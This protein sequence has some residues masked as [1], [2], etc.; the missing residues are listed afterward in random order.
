M[1]NGEHIEADIIVACTGYNLSKSYFNF[2][3]V[4]RN[5]ANISEE[6]KKDGPSA[7]R[8]LLVKQSP[9]LWTIGVP[10]QLLDMHL[11]SWQLRMVLIISSRLPNQS[12]KEK[13]NQLELPT[14][15]TTTG[16]Q[17]FKRIE[18]SVF[19]TP[20]GGCVSWY[21]DAKVNSTVYPWSQFHYWW[22]TFPKL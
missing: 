11:L 10:I 17:L 22:I 16:L 15:L 7:Y 6:W 18:K 4:G 12:L 14:K 3:I 8:T 2:E 19:G 20:F 9:N 21:S 1:K 5:G 13:L